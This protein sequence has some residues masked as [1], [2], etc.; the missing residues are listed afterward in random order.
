MMT[1]ANNK[2]HT[3]FSFTAT[4][5][6]RY[7]VYKRFIKVVGGEITEDDGEHVTFEAIV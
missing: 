4:N 3:T 6:K 7:S 5:D 2:G 1:V